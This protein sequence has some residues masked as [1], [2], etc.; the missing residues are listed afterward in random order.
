MSKKDDLEVIKKVFAYINQENIS[1]EEMGKNPCERNRCFFSKKLLS[2]M[3]D[4]T[5]LQHGKIEALKF[6]AFLTSA[7]PS[8][9]EEMSAKGD[10]EKIKQIFAYVN[11]ENISGEEMGV[12]NNQVNQGKKP[13]LVD[14]NCGYLKSTPLM[15]AASKGHHQVCEYLITRQEANLEA[16]DTLGQTA[17][18]CAARLNHPE[19]IKVLLNHNANCKAK[20]RHGWHAASEAALG[21]NLDALKIL[22]EKDGDVIDLK[23]YNG[24]TPL[25]AALRERR[26]DVCK[27]LVEEL[28]ANVDLKDDDGRT[29]LEHAYYSDITKILKKK[30]CVTKNKRFM[31]IFHRIF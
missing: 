22:V 13:T 2:Q 3:W 18:I 12:K 9:L 24:Q 25:I 10:L 30:G 14:T 6:P 15:S 19:V 16:R 23:G 17:L 7:I 4:V 31:S 8:F 1:M 11:Q 28:N 20:N 5:M 21:G 26:A 27:F 29:A